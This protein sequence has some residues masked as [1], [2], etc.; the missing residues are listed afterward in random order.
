[1]G[2][3]LFRNE[4]V[5]GPFD[6]I[7]L[8]QAIANGTMPPEQ[9]C[10]HEGSD[11][12]VKASDMFRISG[13]SDPP[14][15]PFSLNTG[16]KPSILARGNWLTNKAVLVSFVISV[17]GFGIL[18]N[19]YV[20]IIELRGGGNNDRAATTSSANG[21]SEQRLLAD[22]SLI[23][24]RVRDIDSSLSQLQSQ[25][26]QL[27]AYEMQLA[28]SGDFT[29]ST[30]IERGPLQKVKDE[31]HRLME[32]KSQLADQLEVINSQLK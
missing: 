2:V 13:R 19:A 17:V 11:E 16:V 5:E 21:P 23:I 31:T 29:N 12:W 32:E 9:M 30:S 27:D 20:I 7:V 18:V 1:M 10:C 6:E 4:I 24:D 25:A 26:Q 22:R 15:A 3:Y 14:N 8:Q 28:R